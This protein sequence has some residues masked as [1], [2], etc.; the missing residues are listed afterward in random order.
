MANPGQNETHTAAKP[1]AIAGNDMAVMAFLNDAVYAG[2]I[3][4]MLD[5][6]NGLAQ[7]LVRAGVAQHEAIDAISGG[8]RQQDLDELMRDIHALRAC[9]RQ[10]VDTHRGRMSSADIV[11]ATSGLNSLLSGAQ[12]CCVV[13][14]ADGDTGLP[15]TL[16]R[17]HCGA[18][19]CTL[20]LLVA[21]VLAHFLCQDSLIHVSVCASPACGRYFIERSGKKAANGAPWR[22]VETASSKPR[23]ASN[24][25]TSRR[26]DQAF[27]ARRL[28]SAACFA[29]LPQTA[30][31][32]Q[33][34]RWSLVVS[35]KWRTQLGPSHRF[36]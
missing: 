4:G 30:M 29:R 12:T 28:R 14:A 35:R 21:E 24:A 23:T 20:L 34:L 31:L 11:A 33:R 15:F 2:E 7:W 10:L 6:A 9:F 27:A 17:I 36:T 22:D 5:S 1:N 8:T 19:A 16:R 18:S 32:H 26:L 3:D 25:A 13:I